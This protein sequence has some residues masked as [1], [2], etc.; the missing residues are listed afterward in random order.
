MAISEVYRLSMIQLPGSSIYLKQIENVQV[1]AGIQSM[2]GMGAGEILPS[3]VATERQQPVIT[4]RTSALKTLLDNVG[5]SGLSISTPLY[6]YFR[7]ASNTGNVAIATTVHKRFAVNMGHLFWSA[8]NLPNGG[9]GSAECAIH[10]GYN[11][12][13]LPIVFSGTVAVP[14]QPLMAEYFGAGPVTL[15]AGT[16]I[17][18]VQTITINSG[19]AL[20]KLN[21]CSEIYDTFIGVNAGPVTIQVECLDRVNWESSGLTTEGLSITDVT[22]CYAKKK[23]NKGTNNV[24]DGTAEH[25]EFI[26]SD[27]RILPDTSGSD[28][29][30]PVS[31]RFNIEMITSDGTTALMTYDTTAAIT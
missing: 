12:T 14:A 19:V 22:K 2:L 13:N 26:C 8:I 7:K 11:G 10:C 17:C 16:P 30:R 31:D 9:Q 28:M 18:S 1:S 6:L 20:E 4:F 21:G 5:V 25:I 3:F 15:N 29:V 24:A 23:A 27:G